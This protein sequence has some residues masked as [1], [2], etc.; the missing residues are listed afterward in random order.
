MVRRPFAIPN[1]TAK[2]AATAAVSPN[3]AM[4]AN[5]A[6]SSATAKRAIA[7]GWMLRANMS[8]QMRAA[9]G[10][11]EDRKQMRG[12]ARR[13]E[14]VSR[15][16]RRHQQ[17]RPT[18]RRQDGARRLHRLAGWGCDVGARAR[19][20]EGVQR[21]RDQSKQRGVDEIG[22]APAH[23]LEQNMGRGPA[24]RR[25]EAARK[26]ERRDRPPRGG[27]E[28]ATER[29]KGRIVKGRSGGDAEQQPDREISGGM[30]GY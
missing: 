29:G 3:S 19:Q 6:S 26:R 30:I 25:G 15:E 23:S 21:R 27:A 17:E 10:A 24:H 12:Q 14:G 1:I 2:L 13:H 18:G 9:T 28:D 11:A 22:A 8:S 7:S 5:A 20:R 4:S 16:R